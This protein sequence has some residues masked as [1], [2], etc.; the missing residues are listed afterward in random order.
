MFAKGWG[1]RDSVTVR[2]DETVGDNL[3]DN[4]GST[5]QST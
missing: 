2:G 3:N 4:H 5:N 1:W